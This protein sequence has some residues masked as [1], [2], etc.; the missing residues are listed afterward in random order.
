MHAEPS[1]PFEPPT[2]TNSSTTGSSP[3]Q[4]A[5]HTAAFVL[6]YCVLAFFAP[7]G[8]FWGLGKEETVPISV[9]ATLFAAALVWRVHRPGMGR[10]MRWVLTVILVFV[11]I[12]MWTVALTIR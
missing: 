1:N 3:Q 12:L 10:S 9:V 11:Q 5:H 4:R 8:L 2:S 6:L 7:P